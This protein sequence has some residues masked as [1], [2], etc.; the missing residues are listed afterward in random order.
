MRNLTKQVTCSVCLK[1]FKEPFCCERLEKHARVSQ[2]HVV[3]ELDLNL[4]E[5]EQVGCLLGI[6]VDT[7]GNIAVT[8][9]YK[10]CVY[11]FDKNGKCLGKIGAK[12]HLNFHVA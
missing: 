11:I 2:R 3:G 7:E 10:H 9:C 8:D 5:G 4:L 12:G 6:A 1:T